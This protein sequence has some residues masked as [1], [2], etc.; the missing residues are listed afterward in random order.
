MT[1][2]LLIDVML[3]ISA[4]IHLAP[5]VGVLSLGHLQKLYGIEVAGP[6]LAVLLRHR[7][8]L[9]GILGGLLVWG[10]VEHSDRDVAVAA[11]LA[12]DLVF[13]VLCWVHRDHNAQLRTV[14]RADLV[15]IG[16]LVVAGVAL[17]G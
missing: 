5:V 14:L 3:G 7:A 13:A 11:V 2:D 1:R 17:L 16:A 6:D 9:F 4:L 8:V 10:I 12:S 15:S